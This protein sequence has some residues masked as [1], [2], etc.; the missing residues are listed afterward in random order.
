M[1]FLFRR[2]SVAFAVLSI[3]F[4]PH[5]VSASELLESEVSGKT[6]MISCFDFEPD[7]SSV[8]GPVLGGAVTLR[9]TTACNGST[10]FT[11]TIGGGI[12][13]FVDFRYKLKFSLDSRGFSRNSAL[14]IEA[15]ASGLD[16]LHFYGFGNERYYRGSGYREDDF[17][18]PCQISTFAASVLFPLK[19]NGYWSAGIFGKH[20][21]LDM[22][23]GSYADLHRAEIPGI[24]DSFSGS[25]RFGF[26][27]DTRAGSVQRDISSAQ[28]HSIPAEGIPPLNSALSGM[29]ADVEAAHHPVFFGNSHAFTR[30]SAEV[31][32]YI[33]VTRDGFSRIAFR[34]GGEKIWGDY[35]FRE[36]AYLGGSASLRG[37]D[38][39][40]FAGDAS[41]YAG[42]ELRMRAGLFSVF[43]PVHWGT[44][45]FL[46]SGRVFLEGEDSGAWHTGAGCGLWLGTADTRYTASI[47]YGRGFDG[48]RLMD[49]VGIYARAGF[50]F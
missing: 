1:K 31:R 44:L 18:I 45:V 46:E 8:Y 19:R 34:A 6:G 27:Y 22:I 38:R 16:R 47:A 7:Y 21:D 10:P 15:S 14:R 48:G 11:A 20:V 4:S 9:Q 24:D 35:P 26:H 50:S 23:P 25:F 37:Y 13:P 40:R 36:A 49:D 39:Q 41:L 33:P 5:A 29:L 28:G 2:A 42:S 32:T 30:L 17:E 43:V 12:A 3:T